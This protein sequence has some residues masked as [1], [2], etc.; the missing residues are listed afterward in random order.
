M[1]AHQRRSPLNLR[2]CV[3]LLDTRDADAWRCACACVS[4]GT[5]SALPASAA[6]TGRWGACHAR[7]TGDTSAVES[8]HRYRVAVSMALSRSVTRL[9]F[10]WGKFLAGSLTGDRCKGVIRPSRML[11]VVVDA[12]MRLLVAMT[13]IRSDGARDVLALSESIHI[14]LVRCAWPTGTLRPA[15]NPEK[16]TFGPYAPSAA[17]FRMV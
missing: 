17:S 14:V 1:H 11:V 5:D 12:L 9:R 10:V 7:A 3:V 16:A 15:W 13:R 6:S 4:A 2:A 8:P